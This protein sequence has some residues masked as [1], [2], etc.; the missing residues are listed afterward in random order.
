MIAVEPTATTKDK[1][2]SRYRARISSILS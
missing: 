1:L 2:R